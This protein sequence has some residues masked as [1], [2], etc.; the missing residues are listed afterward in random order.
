[1]NSFIN[2]NV[3]ADS[4]QTINIDGFDIKIEE[5]ENAVTASTITDGIK[6]ELIFDKSEDSYT[7]KTEQDGGIIDQALGNL[8]SD[9]QEV[10]IED[11]TPENITAT[12][13]DGDIIEGLEI[14]DN[15]VIEDGNTTEA[16][17]P[18]ILYLGEA[19]AAALIQAILA[20]TAT[21]VI[22]GATWYAASTAIS[23]LKEKQPKV[24][25]YTA[26]LRNGKV[27]I[28]SAIKSQSAAA[29][30]LKT[31][32]DVFATSQQYALNAAKSASPTGIVKHEK[33]GSGSN[34]YWH[35]HGRNAQNTKNVTGHSFHK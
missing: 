13:K 3:F 22:G 15:K 12:I 34:Y 29:A 9:S 17:A 26:L 11:A 31:N 33:H 4:E 30:R 14:Q 32:Y 28:K 10:I 2:T 20:T 25:Y 27:Y 24:H 5:T 7:L 6:H 19:A 23:K 1:M 21:I 18:L 8:E 35:Y 16:Q